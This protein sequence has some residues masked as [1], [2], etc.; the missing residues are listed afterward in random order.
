MTFRSKPYLD[1]VR[2]HD[3]CSCGLVSIEG[4][5]SEAHHCAH[6][7]VPSLATGGGR[8]MKMGDAWTI[9][10]CGG[11]NS[12]H[13]RW[14]ASL[15]Y[16]RLGDRTVAESDILIAVTQATLMSVWIR[17]LDPDSDLF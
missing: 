16:R 11:P 2:S 10:V 6:P 3:C 15:T 1:Y 12:C 4:R 7:D 14:H 9:P 5:R 13:E 17:R 8:G